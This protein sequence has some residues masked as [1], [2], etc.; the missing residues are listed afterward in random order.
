M[1]KR[2][3]FDI[4][5]TL[6]PWKEEYFEEINNVLDSL[7]IE[8]TQDDVDIIK[9]AFG[10]YENKYYTFDRKLMLEFINE[11]TKKQYPDEFIYG[12][13]DRWAHCV[14]E[15][16]DEN[17]VNVLKYLKDKYQMVILTDWYADQ[18]MERLKKIDVLKYFS[19]VYSAENVKRKPFKEAFMQAIE[20]NKPE[21]CI[22]IGDDF[23]RD[24]KGA[25]NAGLHAIYFNPKNSE[26]KD[27]KR[28][29][30]TISKLV[31]IK[32]IL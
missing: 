17:V 5:N 7:N 26:I 19:K 11:Y 3:I 8:H 14:P 12:C 13:T 24:I 28:Q 10:E 32:D 1:I 4:D 25:L 23:E 31:E 21:E 30:Y 16:L 6:I 27:E 9:K 18:Q 22:M 2:V 29:F 20:E 15:K